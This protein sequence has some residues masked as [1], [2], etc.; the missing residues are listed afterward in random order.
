MGIAGLVVRVGSRKEGTALAVHEESLVQVED[1]SLVEHRKEAYQGNRQDQEGR[2]DPIL[3]VEGDRTV[4]DTQD[5]AQRVDLAADLVVVGLG[6][7]SEDLEEH[8]VEGL[9]AG[10]DA[11]D[12]ELG[13]LEQG[14]IRSVKRLLGSC[15]NNVSRYKKGCSLKIRRKATENLHTVLRSRRQYDLTSENSSSLKANDCCRRV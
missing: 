5:V 8:F 7:G 2:H 9:V 6:F 15:C 3:P 10:F 12:P 11:E 4:E 1:T 13:E 14:A